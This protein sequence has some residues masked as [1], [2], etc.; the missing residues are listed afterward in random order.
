MN[1][2][3]ILSAVAMLIAGLEKTGASA[4][5]D[6]SVTIT[7]RIEP[8]LNIRLAETKPVGG[9]SAAGVFTEYG[10]L[11]LTMN[12]TSDGPPSGKSPVGA[13]VTFALRGNTGYQLTATAGADDFVGIAPQNVKFGIGNARPSGDRVMPDAINKLQL[14]PEF[15][16]DPFA[17][18]KATLADL[19][20]KKVLMRGPCISRGGTWSTPGNAL[21]VDTY[22]AITPQF[23][24]P[25]VVIN[26]T[27]TI[28]VP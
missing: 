20:N 5:R 27:Y 3:I 7:G 22:Y 23:F 25:P 4:Q 15:A 28:S 21:F 17:G 6:G 13:V 26:I 11:S 18:G 9:I 14:T 16:T 12:F 19:A 1:R 2:L 10:L 24:A 8:A